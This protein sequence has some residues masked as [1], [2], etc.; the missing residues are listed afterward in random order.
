MPDFNIYP[1]AELQ[2][3]K[4]TILQYGE[5]TIIRRNEYFVREGSLCNEI[6]YI[7]TGSFKYTRTNSKGKERIFAFMLE[8][9]LIANYIPAR[10]QRPALLNIQAMETSVIYKITIDRFL[11]FFEKE[12]DGHI[13]VHK[14][15]EI[16]AFG[17]LQKM[18]SL[19]CQ[20]PE[21]KYFEL[22]KRIPDLFYRVNLKDIASYIGIAPETLSRMRTAHLFKSSE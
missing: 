2:E 16:I 8:N 1:E 6:A 5:K 15:S 14:F 18:I 22:Q 11:S 3:L 4:H 10:I 12:I 13:Y 21:E 17:H 20:T 7:Q 19:A 9:E